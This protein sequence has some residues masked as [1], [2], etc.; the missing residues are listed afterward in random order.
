MGWNGQNGQTKHMVKL[1][2][3]FPGGYPKTRV[4]SSAGTLLILVNTI[5]IR[6]EISIFENKN[7]KI[8]I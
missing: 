4:Y 8:V 2:T 1:Y 3:H 7:K 6:E 5:F